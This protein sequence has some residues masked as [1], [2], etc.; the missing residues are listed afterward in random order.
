MAQRPRLA[1][2]QPR[3]K[4]IMPEHLYSSDEE[5]HKK[6]DLAEKGL[7]LNATK[8]QPK[9]Q[10]LSLKRAQ[11]IR[12]KNTV[13]PWVDPADREALPELFKN[14][15]EFRPEYP[16]IKEVDMSMGRAIENKVRQC[17][18]TKEE[19]QAFK[20][21]AEESSSPT[22]SMISVSQSKLDAVNASN[23]KPPV[24]KLDLH[25]REGFK[26][27]MRLDNTSVVSSASF[28]ALSAKELSSGDKTKLKQRIKVYNDNVIFKRRS[29][30]F[31]KWKGKG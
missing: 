29:Q 22:K 27:F 19:L 8:P 18:M 20:E 3:A 2:G 14:R 7:I 28:T 5:D 15:A 16:N 31:Y 4:V 30:F 12:V 10:F 25:A 17:L 26:Q 9:S 24:M 21:E 6:N 23:S 11:K 1:K 13:K